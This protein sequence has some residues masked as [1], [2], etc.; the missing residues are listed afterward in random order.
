MPVELLVDAI[1]EL[2]EDVVVVIVLWWMFVKPVF[3]C[4]GCDG[5]AKDVVQD[6][7]VR[8]NNGKS[9]VL[10]TEWTDGIDYSQIIRCLLD[11]LG[12]LFGP[13]INMT[14][15]RARSLFWYKSRD[16]RCRSQVGCS[17]VVSLEVVDVSFVDGA[18]LLYPRQGARTNQDKNIL[19]H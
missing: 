17:S 13:Q 12:S 15:T 18:S 8:P 5:S 16:W 10:S 7:L 14:S 3:G 4:L 1:G 2:E 19:S 6:N 11:I 9:V